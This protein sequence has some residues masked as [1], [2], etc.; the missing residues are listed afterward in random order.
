MASLGQ[1][2]AMQC[3]LAPSFLFFPSLLMLKVTGVYYIPAWRYRSLIFFLFHF[4]CLL[5][6]CFLRC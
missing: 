1:D 3:R 5:F 4:V 2:I 6:V